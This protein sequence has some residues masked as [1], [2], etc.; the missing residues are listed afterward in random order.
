MGRWDECLRLGEEFVVEAG[1]RHYQST[2]FFEFRGRVRLARGD[3]PGA[4]ED[5]ELALSQSREIKDPQRLQPAVAFAAFALLSAGR[6]AECE[7][8]VEELL[9]LD[10]V[11][12][13]IPAWVAPVLELAWI[14]TRLGRH[15]E[16]LE[17]AAKA[18]RD[19]KWLEA[20]TALARGEVELAGD[21]CAEIGVL[22]NEAY[23]R[24]RA[25]EKLLEQGRRADADTQLRSAL[26]FYRSV[27]ASFYVREAEA[28]MAESA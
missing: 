28:L 7:E 16:F 21:I 26:E 11:G 12:I 17:A 15:D 20:A 10:P 6:I 24:L 13:P 8:L 22:P 25:A 5:S 4:L 23:T 2:T 3:L 14:L 27:G 19:T 18:K 9:A 1:P